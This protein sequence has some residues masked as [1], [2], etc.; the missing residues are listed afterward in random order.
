MKYISKFLTQWASLVACVLLAGVCFAEQIH[1][2]HCKNGCP[3]STASNLISASAGQSEIIVRHL[4][5]A[6]ISPAGLAEW[7]TYRVLP[8]TVGVA[9]LLPRYWRLD[10]LSRVASVLESEV[11]QSTLIVQADLSN[12]QDRDYRVNEVTLLEKDRGRLVPM[13]S[14]AGTPYWDELNYLSNM[15]LLPTSLRT[16]AWSRLD[17]AVNEL[18]QTGSSFHVISGPVYSNKLEDGIGVVP[19]LF[20]KVIAGTDGLAAFA[21]PSA[22]EPQST[23]CDYSLSLA[24]ISAVSGLDF[25]PNSNNSLPEDLIVDLG[26]QR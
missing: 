7:V 12:S 19:A 14:F 11:G 2:A 13:T 3:V 22:I 1:I 17:Q 25:F 4:Y 6:S 26:C 10:E 8:E 15:S 23:F 20:F 18:A 21:F 24:E 9:S 16:G 5:A